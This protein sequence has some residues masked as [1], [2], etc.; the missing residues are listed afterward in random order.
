MIWFCRTVLISRFNF[1]LHLKPNY[2]HFQIMITTHEITPNQNDCSLDKIQFPSLKNR[3][4][5]ILSLNLHSTSHSRGITV[6]ILI[7]NA[8]ILVRY[9]KIN[10]SCLSCHNWY[11]KLYISQ[12]LMIENINCI[13]MSSISKQILI[14]SGMINL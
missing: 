3:F 12:L 2:T 4:R 14:F 6:T 9:N 5:L 8:I 13:Q 11:S 1:D 7:Q 10:I